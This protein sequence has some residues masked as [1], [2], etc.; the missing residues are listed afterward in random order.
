M[1]RGSEEAEKRLA[2]YRA[3]ELEGIHILF[4]YWFRL[5]WRGSFLCTDKRKVPK[6]KLPPISYPADPFTAA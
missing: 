6:R 3:G 4:G 2:A 5:L 1:E